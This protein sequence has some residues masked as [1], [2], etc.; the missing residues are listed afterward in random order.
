MYWKITALVNIF[1]WKPQKTTL[2]NLCGK[3]THWNAMGDITEQREGCN[4]R[5]GRAGIGVAQDV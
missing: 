4:T 2:S 5:C 1:G 3:L